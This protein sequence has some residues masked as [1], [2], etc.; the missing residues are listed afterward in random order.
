MGLAMAP[1]SMD[2]MASR[3]WMRALTSPLAQT[4]PL[5]MQLTRSKNP[6]QAQMSSP[7]PP[8]QTRTLGRMLQHCRTVHR[9][10]ITCAQMA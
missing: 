6:P 9:T 3:P 4:L 7:N 10:P 2:K 5:S 8:A 1:L